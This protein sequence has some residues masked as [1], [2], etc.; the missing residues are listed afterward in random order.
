MVTSRG[1]IVNVNDIKDIIISGA[2][3]VTTGGTSYH[4]IIPIPLLSREVKD[5]SINSISGTFRQGG[6]YIIGDSNENT[7]LLSLGFI[8]RKYINPGFIHINYISNSAPNNVS[9]ND[10]FGF[11]LHINMKFL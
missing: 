10:V 4:F 2:G 5:V 11:I 1:G 7:N 9:N 6:N 3:F 8:N